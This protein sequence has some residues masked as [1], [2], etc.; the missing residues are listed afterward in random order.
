MHAAKAPLLPA[1]VS[2]LPTYDFET[3]ERLLYQLRGTPVVV[4]IWASWCG[5]C[6]AEA[7]LLVDAARQHA[8]QI[9]FIGV[10]YQDAREAAARFASRYHVPYP[11]VSDAGQIHDSLGFVGLPDTVFYEASGAILATWTGPL[12]SD[13]LRQNLERLTA[14]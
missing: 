2:A 14:G 5:P 3:F 8:D 12:T 9:Q 6:R 4:N 10:D 13:S 1:T 11:S 7:P